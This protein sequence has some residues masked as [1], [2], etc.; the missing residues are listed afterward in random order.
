[1]LFELQ[2]G[3]P[4]STSKNP[5][6]DVGPAS[7][8][9]IANDHRSSRTR[10]LRNHN[11]GIGAAGS[12]KATEC[13]CGIGMENERGVVSGVFSN[14]DDFGSQLH[15]PLHERQSSGVDRG[16]SGVVICAIQGECARARLDD[17][18]LG[19]G[20][21]GVIYPVIIHDIGVTR[22]PGSAEAI[23]REIRANIEGHIRPEEQIGPISGAVDVSTPPT[24]GIRLEIP[25]DDRQIGPGHDE[26]GTART[27]SPA[28]ASTRVI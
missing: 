8:R 7:A 4:V 27:Q 25:P 19:I 20:I 17:A 9:A 11:R 1:M 16:V 13:Q 2:L 24:H 26:N 10:I 23:D 14:C 12:V 18:A 6:S 21:V 3:S 28:A 22:I 5:G 15:R